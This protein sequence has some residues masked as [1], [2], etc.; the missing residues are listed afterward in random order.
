M[1]TKTGAHVGLLRQRP[2][3]SAKGGFAGL[4]RTGQC[5]QALG[6]AAGWGTWLWGC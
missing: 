2:G 4:S 1:N 6:C 5:W 3:I